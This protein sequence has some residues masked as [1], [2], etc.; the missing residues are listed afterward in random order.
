[1]PGLAQVFNS[2]INIRIMAWSFQANESFDGY[3]QVI[4]SA[5]QNTFSRVTSQLR[6]S[7]FPDTEFHKRT[8]ARHWKPLNLRFQ[9]QKSIGTIL[10]FAVVF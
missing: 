9:A 5:C 2:F 6:P 8:G 3:P 4:T 7:P 1:M 10:A